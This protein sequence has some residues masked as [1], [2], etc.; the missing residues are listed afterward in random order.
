MLS[1]IDV[2]YL[3]A[4]LTQI[5]SPWGVEIELGE[6]VEDCAAEEDR[7]VDITVRYASPDKELTLSLGKRKPACWMPK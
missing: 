6:M 5:A 7:D 3:A 1:H 4:I 2:H